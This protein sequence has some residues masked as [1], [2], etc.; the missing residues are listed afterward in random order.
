LPNVAEDYVH[1]IGR[2]GRAGAGG[3]ALSLVSHDELDLLKGIQR[4]LRR[5]I[6]LDPVPGFE[7]SSVPPAAEAESSGD[8]RARPA[9]T[10]R[11]PRGQSPRRGQARPIEPRPAG[12][13]SRGR[14]G[15]RAEP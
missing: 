4:L 11:H 12:G 9:N 8:R 10:A 14:A 5:E 1:R 7:P 13:R 2:T 3:R 15:T 6:R